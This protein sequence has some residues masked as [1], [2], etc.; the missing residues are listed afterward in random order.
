MRL[1]FGWVL[2]AIVGL[3]CGGE[4][5]SDAVDSAPF[6]IQVDADGLVSRVA[7]EMCERLDDCCVSEDYEWFFGPY[8]TDERNADLVAELDQSSQWDRESCVSFLKPAME[9]TWLGAWLLAVEEGLVEFSEESAGT[10]IAAIRTAECGE[11]IRTALTDSACFGYAAPSGGEH[12]R[13]SFVRSSNTGDACSPIADGFGGLYYGSCDPSES[14]CCVDTEYGCDPFPGTTERGE[15]TKAGQVGEACNSF[16]LQLC[17]TGA[18]CIENECVV[19][20]IDALEVGEP[21]YDSQKFELLGYCSDSWCD[22]T[23]SAACEPMHELGQDCASDWEC[24][25]GWCDLE[26]SMCDS[27]PICTE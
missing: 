22:V 16:P 12:Q 11:S 19:V 15:C 10:C 13:S 4:T 20:S 27:H 24:E 26:L 17:V 23:G 14:F 5:G 3:A 7:S 21:C 18:E 8:I 1:F 2:M 6:E 25:S 9:N